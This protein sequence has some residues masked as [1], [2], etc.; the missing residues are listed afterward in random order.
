MASSIGRRAASPAASVR[1]ARSRACKPG[2]VR[3]DS[4]CPS[5]T[6]PPQGSRYTSLVYPEPNR[7]LLR[8]VRQADGG[9]PRPAGRPPVG[10][11]GAPPTAATAL[12]DAPLL[13]G[14]VHGRR[15]ERVSTPSQLV[16]QRGDPPL[17]ACSRVRFQQEHQAGVIAQEGCQHL[18]H[19][20]P[21]RLSNPVGGAERHEQAFVMKFVE[22]KLL[23]GKRLCRQTGASH[24]RVLLGLGPERRQGVPR[25]TTSRGLGPDSL[26][27]S[28]HTIW[29]CGQLTGH[30]VDRHMSATSAAR[31]H[32]ALGYVAEQL[33]PGAQR[34]E[35][36]E[37]LIL[38][39][40]HTEQHV[41]EQPHRPRQCMVPCSA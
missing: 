9:V 38:V 6:S 8:T 30:V 5:R 23:L 26:A 11:C 13:P 40:L 16:G 21:R 15:Q 2:S 35:L 33:L 3:H 4:R 19:C 14:Q 18:Y 12:F 28:N 24:S 22:I 34:P 27:P 20:R 29:P 36:R 1:S 31:L 41:V 37:F 25:S 10:R 39:S 17:L 7:H 32:D